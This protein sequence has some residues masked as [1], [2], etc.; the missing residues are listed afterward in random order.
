M[1]APIQ[2]PT[3][4]CAR[5]H[6]QVVDFAMLTTKYYS[7]DVQKMDKDTLVTC[8]F[9]SHQWTEKLTAWPDWERLKSPY[10]ELWLADPSCEPLEALMNR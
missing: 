2:S 6:T 9:E 8:P 5:T 7:S 3:H 4:A 10:H 1:R